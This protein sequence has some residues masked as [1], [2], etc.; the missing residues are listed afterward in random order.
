MIVPAALV[1]SGCAAPLMRLPTGPAQP[2]PD[3]PSILAEAT[4]TCRDVSSMVAD[5][6]VRGSVASRRL[7]GQLE[8]GLAAPGSARLD[9][10]APFGLLF[11]F[12]ARGDDAT[13]V[14]HREDRVLE[15][16]RPRAVLEAVTGVPLDA[17]GLRLALTG[18]ALD[19]AITEASRPNDDWRIVEQEQQRLY[20]SRTGE[21][22]AWRLVAAVQGDA[23]RTWRA[24]YRAFKDGLPREVR[25]TSTDDG[26]FDL[27]LTLSQ[28]ETNVPLGPETFEVKVPGSASPITLEEL[29]ES[30]PLA[31]TGAEQERAVAGT[32]RAN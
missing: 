16:G 1:V 12:V 30:G 24:E 26:R 31:D 29:R 23:G 17:A 3:A 2:A 9:A 10:S 15:H 19:A 11:T 21:R 7:R 28:V 6:A 20:L 25:L 22:G 13:L 4:K 5:V 32:G 27:R 18:C 8:V 14:L